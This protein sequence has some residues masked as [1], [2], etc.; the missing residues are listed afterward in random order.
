VSI[1]RTDTCTI[2]PAIGGLPAEAEAKG[3]RPATGEH[4]CAT[5]YYESHG[6]MTPNHRTSADAG[7]A[8]LFHAGHFWPR[9][10]ECGRSACHDTGHGGTNP[11]GV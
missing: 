6:A 5:G 4:E 1:V 10:A 11:R 2:G 8:F 3:G 7:I 9:A